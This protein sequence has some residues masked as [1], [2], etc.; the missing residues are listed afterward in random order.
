MNLDEK[1]VRER[2]EGMQM[3]LNDLLAQFNE[4]AKA[5]NLPELTIDDE[6]FVAISAIGRVTSKDSDICLNLSG[7]PRTVALGCAGIVKSV[8][9]D[10]H[11]DYGA[12][13][14]SHAFNAIVMDIIQ[15]GVSIGLRP[16]MPAIAPYRSP[17]SIQMLQ[18]G[19]NAQLRQDEQKGN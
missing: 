10:M 1:Q 4:A 14:A 3:T 19:L 9:E 15:F 6:G 11:D 16:T 13:M 5:N 8:L 17:A 7:S 12:E 18:E 2:E